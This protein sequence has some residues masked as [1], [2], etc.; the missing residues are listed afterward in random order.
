MSPERKDLSDEELR[1][2]TLKRGR[3]AAVG[4]VVLAAIIAVAAWALLR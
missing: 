4:F 2:W 1:E 3:I